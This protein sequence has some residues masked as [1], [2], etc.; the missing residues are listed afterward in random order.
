LGEMG[1]KS[2]VYFESL[3]RADEFVMT[4]IARGIP[5]SSILFASEDA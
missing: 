4:C 1:R 3:D 5:L 2:E